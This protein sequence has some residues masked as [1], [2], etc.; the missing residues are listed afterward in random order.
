MMTV[1]VII[2]VQLSVIKHK[3]IT[4]GINSRYCTMYCQFINC[5]MR[6]RTAGKM[7]TKNVEWIRFII[8]GIHLLF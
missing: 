2:F 8:L 3:N 7:Y 6:I 4:L 5:H 1:S